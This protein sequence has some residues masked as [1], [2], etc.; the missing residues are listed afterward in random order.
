MRH[1]S[2]I[3]VIA[4]AVVLAVVG[5]L[6]LRPGDGGP[7]RSAS[8]APAPGAPAPPVMSSAPPT[9]LPDYGEEP[10]APPSRKAPSD[11]SIQKG[12]EATW[13]GNLPA[14]QGR[15]LV[16]LA[17]AVV[18]ADLTGR[19]RARWPAYFPGDPPRA[20]YSRVRLRAG[21]ARGVPSRPDLAQV[22]VVWAG[23]DPRGR[24]VR[25][26]RTAVCLGRDGSGWRPRIP[27][28]CA[29]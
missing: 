5:A 17:W 8:G 23:R 1:G 19:G 10:D 11:S 18:R 3:L 27:P 12:L 2:T 14:D 21:V 20:R 6:L 26:N 28:A 7:R 15:E 13:P 22:I 24:E 16:A 25:Q 9:T 4:A 29:R